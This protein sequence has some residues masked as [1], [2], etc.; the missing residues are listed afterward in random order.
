[1]KII[2]FDIDSLRA[3]HL[4]CYSYHRN[5]SPT[6][7]AIANEGIRFNN[8]YTSDAPCGPS[9]SALLTGQFGIHNGLIAHADTAGDMFR[10]GVGRWFFSELGDSCLANQFRKAGLKTATITPFAERHS[11]WQWYA[12]YNEIYN[13]GKMGEE[14]AEDITPVALD[15]L[16]RNAKDDNWFIHINLWDPHTPYRV[17]KEYGEPFKDDPL[18]EWYTE[19]IRQKHWDGVGSWSAQEGLG[20]GGEHPYNDPE[21]YPRQ[22][23]QI[24]SMKEAR[25][26]FDG[27]DTGIKYM[28]DHVKLIIDELKK[29]KLYEDT[30]I[31]ISAD[32]GENLGE[33]NIYYDHQTADGITPRVP[34]IFKWPGVTDKYKGESYDALHYQFDLGASLVELAGSGVPNNWDGV[35]IDDKIKSGKD[36]GRNFLVLSQGAHTCQRSVRFDDYI[37]IRSYHDGY[38]NYPDFML[39]NI[40]HD[41]HEQN[42]LAEAKP[43]LVNQ[44]M[45]YLEEW[46]GDMMRTAK[47][48]QDPMWFVM[49]EGG[50]MHTRLG[51]KDYVK[52]LKETGREKQAEIMKSKHPELTEEKNEV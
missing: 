29:Q 15:W 1:M 19:E 41:P 21:K 20:Y 34:F 5:T 48:P 52:R 51:V 28:D 42:D 4:G 9:R 39:Y 43:E 10:E 26:M 30:A 14:S 7:D 16:K 22:P 12:G 37:C 6:I 38:H 32:H 18:P 50:P 2:Y 17:P 35:S 11:I 27:Y 44:A 33:L 8:C 40:K 25:K 13:T 46:H 36:E 31:I 24:S 49:K 45:K 23:S 47:H 3:D